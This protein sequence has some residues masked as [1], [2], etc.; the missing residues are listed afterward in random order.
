MY[1]ARRRI[2]EISQPSNNQNNN[3]N[4]NKHIVNLAG[5]PDPRLV[6]ACT[7]CERHV[8]QIFVFENILGDILSYCTLSS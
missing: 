5:R 3:N 2:Y 1:Q 6:A 4:N 7:Q 8:E